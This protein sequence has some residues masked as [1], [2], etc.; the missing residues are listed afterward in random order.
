MERQFKVVDLHKPLPEEELKQRQLDF[1]LSQITIHEDKVPAHK[2]TTAFVKHLK[3]PLYDY[4][5]NNYSYDP[6]S[7]ALKLKRRINDGMRERMLSCLTSFEDETRRNFLIYIEKINTLVKEKYDGQVTATKEAVE[8][9]KN[10][11][12]NIDADTQ[13]LKKF[14]EQKRT[15]RNTLAAQKSSPP[16]V[17]NDSEKAWGIHWR[18]FAED[19][20]TR[21]K[22]NLLNK[23][24]DLKKKIKSLEKEISKLD[25][26]IKPLVEKK[27]KLEKR[28]Q[29][30]SSEQDF[31]DCKLSLEYHASKISKL[32]NRMIPLFD[33]SHE[34]HKQLEKT[35]QQLPMLDCLLDMNSLK[36]DASINF[37]RKV[38]RLRD[39]IHKHIRE[40]AELE[41]LRVN[42][43]LRWREISGDTQELIPVLGLKTD[44]HMYFI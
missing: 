25:A 40:T 22:E 6:G 41:N 31:K 8:S 7:G 27:E 10:H 26:D 32:Q 1:K 30:D 12:N 13:E 43:N 3:N 38:Q 24:F 4:G 29:S 16:R 39:R 42:L 44:S 35:D 19:D 5:L 37:P 11:T 20:L 18:E 2:C 14:H 36:R 9:D 15:E 28:L 23:K 34:L 33:Q 21:S 17:Y